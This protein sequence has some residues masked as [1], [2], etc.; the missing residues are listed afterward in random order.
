MP[1]QNYYDLDPAS[2]EL[3]S[4]NILDDSGE[5]LRVLFTLQHLTYCVCLWVEFVY[6]DT[7]Q[8]FML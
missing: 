3:T 8:P 1:Y 6:A 7:T 5:F 4:G 2:K